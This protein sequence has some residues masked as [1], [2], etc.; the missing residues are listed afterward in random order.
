MAN[1]I[2]VYDACVLYPAPLRDLFLRLALTDLYQAKWTKA[3]HEEWINSLLRK[4]PDLSRNQLEKIREKMDLHVRDALVDNYEE[5]IEKVK[6]PG[7]QMIG[8]SWLLQLD[9]G[10]I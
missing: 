3:I 10:L 1:L 6:L 2:V 9:L 4:R 8:M 5:L 7:T